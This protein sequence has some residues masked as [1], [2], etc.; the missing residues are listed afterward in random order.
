MYK[1]TTK[2]MRKY[3][4]VRKCADTV[5]TLVKNSSERLETV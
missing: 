5:T 2:K 4:E 3:F 1:G